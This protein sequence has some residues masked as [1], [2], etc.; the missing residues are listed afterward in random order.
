MKSQIKLNEIK[1]FIQLWV[2][3]FLRIRSQQGAF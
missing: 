2:V 1:L 3:T